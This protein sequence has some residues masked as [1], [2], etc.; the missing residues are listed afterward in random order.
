MN[1]SGIISVIIKGAPEKPV[2]L[3]S[4]ADAFKEFHQ[5]VDKSYLSISGKTKLSKGDRELYKI[6]ATNIKSGS[7]I[8]EL[9]ITVPPLMQSAFHFHSTGLLNPAGLWE[10][11]KN[12]FKFLKTVASGKSNGQKITIAQH[13]SPYGFNMVNQ[14]G[15]NV[16]INVGTPCSIE[17]LIF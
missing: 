6:F 7:V 9:L 8:A 11:T 10:L 13:N 1:E 16:T 14:E 12:S 5:V 4:V 2:P 17:C 15:G 3:L